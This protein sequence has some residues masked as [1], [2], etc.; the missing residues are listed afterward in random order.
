MYNNK[1]NKN[2]NKIVKY[3]QFFNKKILNLLITKTQPC[4]KIEEKYNFIDKFNIYYY[5]CYL[6]Y[7]VVVNMLFNI[8]HRC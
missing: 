7:Y 2:K 8:L 3:F 4:N 6:I 1:N 5:I